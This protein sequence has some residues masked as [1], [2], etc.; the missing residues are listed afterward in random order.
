MISYRVV[1]A[2]N[3]AVASSA[4]EWSTH[5]ALIDAAVNRKKVADLEAALQAV[6][7]PQ[8]ARELPAAVSK[9]VVQLDA[10][11]A[12]MSENQD[13]RLR[14]FSALAELERLRQL[15]LVS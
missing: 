9:D 15:V 10:Y 6:P 12:A 13:L 14:C 11:K 1:T 5:Q 7:A 3:A 8:A 2:A 4:V